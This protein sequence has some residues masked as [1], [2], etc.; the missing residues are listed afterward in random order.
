MNKLEP[1]CS[2]VPVI[3]AGKVSQ[4]EKP[5]KKID[6]E[7][8]KTLE[9]VPTQRE[10]VREKNCSIIIYSKMILKKFVNST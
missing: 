1:A 4:V 10:V 7:S 6:W 3:N 8:N 5:R 9:K 2:T